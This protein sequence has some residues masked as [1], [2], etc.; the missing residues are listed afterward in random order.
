MAKKLKFAA[1]SLVVVMSLGFMVA[2][3]SKTSETSPS[4]SASA[5]SSGS[6]LHIV[7]G[8]IDPPVTLTTVRGIDSTA[9]FKNGETFENNIHTKWAK[10]TLGVDIKTLWSSQMSDASYDTKLKLMLS[11][12]DKLPDVIFTTSK[13]TLNMFIESGKVMSVDSA[14]DKYAGK[15]WKDAVAEQPD[16]WLPFQRGKQKMAIPRLQ[17]TT[18]SEPVL[19]IR[20]DWMDKLGLQA[21]KSLSDL[22]TIMDAFANKDPDGNGKKDTMALDFAIKDQMVGYPVGDISWLFGAFGSIPDQWTKDTNGKLVFG[23]T[24]PGVKS[25]LAKLKDWKDKGYIADDIALHDW[26]KIVENVA[27]AKVGI[28]AGANWFPAYP[29]SLVY[30][31]DPKADFE[32]YAFP[33]GPD[34]KKGQTVS[35]PFNGGFVISKDISQEALEAFFYYMNTLW[36]ASSSNDPFVLKGFQENYD[37][38]IQDGKAVFDN[39]K[40]PGGHVQTMKYTLQGSMPQPMSKFVE[41]S[42]KIAKGETLTPNDIAFTNANGVNPKDP[43]QGIQG[44]ATLI[45]IDQKGSDMPNLFTGPTTSTQSSRGEFLKKLELDTFNQIIYSKVPIDEFDNFVKKWQSS[46]GDQLTKE[47]NDWYSS[48]K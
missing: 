21:P 8:K 46:G 31:K 15:V 40:I 10:D 18:T 45:T 39:D 35:D 47:V 19:W 24:Q 37:Y 20:K 22:E 17:A 41:V 44:K 3:S 27:S 14:F 4:A 1:S 12:G 2:C 38:V 29:G 16:A 42:K 13:D 30:A 28:V 36:D 5:N 34:G 26:N 7:N 11:S 23:S 43:L 6:K 33:A 9:K 48:V 25:A 32:P